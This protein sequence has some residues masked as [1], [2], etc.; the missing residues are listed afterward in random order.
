MELD[1]IKARGLRVLGGLL[2]LCDD[3]RQFVGRKRARDYDLLATARREHFSVH[4][5]R[6]GGD[7]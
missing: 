7:R 2:E 3:T 5:D 4:R 1:A 6:G